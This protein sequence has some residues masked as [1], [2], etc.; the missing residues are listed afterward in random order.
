MNE[1]SFL[2]REEQDLSLR[3]REL[4]VG[5]VARDLDQMAAVI[6]SAGLNDPYVSWGEIN[7]ARDE[8]VAKIEELKMRI[9]QAQ[10][11]LDAR[12]ETHKELVEAK[13]EIEAKIESKIEATSGS[14]AQK[15]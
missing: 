4:D 12:V 11:S 7:G 13:R 15:A 8:M 6:E 1:M 3:V 2:E 9:K 14:V 10:K 5:T